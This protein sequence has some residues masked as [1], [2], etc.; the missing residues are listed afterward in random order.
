MI[1]TRQW[2]LLVVTL[3]AGLSAGAQPA[4]T[5]AASPTRIVTLGAAV[6]ETVFALGEGARLIARDTSS[7]YP[8]AAALL[9]DVGYFR[10]IGAEG[11]LSLRPDAILAAAGSGPPEQL[12]V[13]AR[14]GVTLTHFDQP[15]GLAATLSMI[16]RTGDLLGRAEVARELVASIEADLAQA[17]ALRAGR[18]APRILFLLGAP[19]GS[20][21]QA[22]GDR[23]AGAAFIELLG[24]INAAAGQ[25][26]Y[27]S[28]SAEGVLTLAPDVIIYGVNPTAESSA[29]TTH[30]LPGW[31]SAGPLAGRIHALPLSYL[32]FGPRLGGAVRE[33]TALI[34]PAGLLASAEAER[35]TL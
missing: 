28:L 11:V 20:S 14:S 4:V 26:G 22:A 33:A 6:T 7:T 1:F 2:S 15:V 35:G 18:P 12:A 5:A 21:A 24:G 25:P 27:K 23:T 32:I 10:M 9:P 8:P 13:L 19:G 30:E 34:Y 3:F 16:T 31:V 29:G 17:A